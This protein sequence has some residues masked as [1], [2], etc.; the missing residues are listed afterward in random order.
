M[1]HRITRGGISQLD[2]DKTRARCRHW[3][4][5]CSVDGERKMRRF[6]GGT[7]REACAALDAWRAELAEEAEASET[8][9]AYVRKWRKW[10]A[11]SG[12]LSGNT[13]RSDVYIESTLLKTPLAAMRLDA[14]TPGDVRDALSWIRAHP[15]AGR[16]LSETTMALVYKMLAS[17]FKQ[18]VTDGLIGSSPMRGVKAPKPDTKERSALS[19]ARVMEVLDAIDAQRLDG[20]T[21]AVALML[22]LGLRVGEACGVKL[23]DIDGGV[24][25]VRHRLGD[26]GLLHPPKTAKGVRDLPMPPR[27]Q[28]T[29]ARWRSERIRRGI[30]DAPMLC[31]DETGRE[32]RP[33]R[34]RDWWNDHRDGYGC[35]GMVTHQLRHSNLSMMAR[36]MPSAFDLQRWAGWSSLEPARV[37]IHAD[38]DALQSAVTSAF[39]YDDVTP[40]PDSPDPRQSTSAFRVL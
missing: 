17:I 28:A 33:R 13:I 32:I 21:V 24:L 19:P 30:G 31:C 1:K 11:E 14:I 29:L 5:S 3:M 20:F 22:S 23:E 26:D 12:A 27:L 16:P 2:K 10:R 18:A 40:S 15:A 37:Y 7:Y 35:A 38:R 34:V 4:L 9:E 36:H 39:G 8:F 25:H 6:S